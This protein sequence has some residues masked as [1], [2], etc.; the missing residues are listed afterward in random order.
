M[1][2]INMR[3]AAIA[4]EHHDDDVLFVT[5]MDASDVIRSQRSK[6]Q[7]L[8]LI[9]SELVDEYGFMESH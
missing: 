5:L 7:E 3:L 8:E 4:S 9:I 1:S 2:D 6:I